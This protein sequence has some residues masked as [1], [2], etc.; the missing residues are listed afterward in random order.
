MSADEMTKLNESE[1]DD[2]Q[3]SNDYCSS[4]AELIKLPDY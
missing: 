3:N 1:M 2:E 4:L